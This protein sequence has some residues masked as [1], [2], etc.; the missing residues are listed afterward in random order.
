MLH[1]GSWHTHGVGGTPCMWGVNTASIHH[2]IP[3]EVHTLATETC[4]S[5]NFKGILK[6]HTSSQSSGFLSGRIWD[7]PSV[8]TGHPWQKWWAGWN[9]QLFHSSW[10]GRGA[11]ECC[12][13]VIGKPHGPWATPPSVSL[14]ALL[15]VLCLTALI[16]SVSHCIPHSRK[17]HSPE[18][19]TPHLYLQPRG[20]WQIYF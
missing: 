18:W 7:C 14:A 4:P 19:L 3:R 20:Y 16:C 17:S 1:D 8:V 6:H 2:P 12:V 5:A 9:D 10:D 13:R 15:F 11:G